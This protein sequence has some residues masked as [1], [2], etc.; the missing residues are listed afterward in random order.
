MC[1]EPL[2]EG[3]RYAVAVTKDSIVD[4]GHVPKIHEYVH[5]FYIEQEA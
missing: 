2:N 1:R 5:C 3:D 4:I